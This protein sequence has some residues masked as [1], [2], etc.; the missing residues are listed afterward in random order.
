MLKQQWKMGQT[1]N[2]N[3]FQKA[4]LRALVDILS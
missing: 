4:H 3:I 2:I 1:K